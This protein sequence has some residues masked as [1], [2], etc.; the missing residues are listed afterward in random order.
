MLSRLVSENFLLRQPQGSTAFSVERII[1]SYKKTGKS[2]CGSNFVQTI[3]LEL[4]L[5]LTNGKKQQFCIDFYFQVSLSC[6]LTQKNCP[7]P[8]LSPYIIEKIQKS[9]CRSH[10]VRTISLELSLPL[11]NG[12][13]QQ[14][15]TDLYFQTCLS[16]F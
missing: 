1:R 16:C 7:T 9:V 10:F 12:K 14:F 15:C 3:S 13:K 2:A 6:F 5:L 11:T 8:H 4:N